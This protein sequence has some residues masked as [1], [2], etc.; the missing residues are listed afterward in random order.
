VSSQAYTPGLKRKELTIV[1]KTRI[2]PIKGEVLVKEGDVVTPNTVIA[3]TVVPGEKH[4]FNVAEKLGVY[5]EKLRDCLLKKEGELFKTNEVIA[6]KTG[7]FGLSKREYKSPVTGTIE[8]ISDITGEVIISEPPVPVEIN[9]YIPGTIETILPKE[10]AIVK[11]TAT[12]LQGIF[13]I[14]GETSGELV[15]LAQHSEDVIDETY[16]KPECNGKIL[17]GGAF[18]TG[19]ALVKAK[20]LGARGIVVG[21]IMNEALHDMLGYEIGVAITGN[22]DIDLT[23][24]IMEGFGKMKMSEH[25][26]ELL[27]KA[28]GRLACINGATQIRAGVIRPEVI[29]PRL[30]QHSSS[31]ELYQEESTTS[32]GLKSGTTIRVIRDPYFGSFGQVVNLPKELQKI[33]TE[34]KVRVLTAKL[35][36]GRIVIVPRADV[37][38]I[39][40]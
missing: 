32:E 29:I 18:I 8:R 31:I 37:E 23:L 6:L 14:G 12:F 22:E 7:F 33:E 25:V 36:D 24:T 28:E 38:I 30:D 20:E 34:S 2:L 27:K 16:I 3:R 4:L 9:A 19:K 26:F 1:K 39:E 17:V 15:M 40:E 13:G 5:P 11:T 10:G 35:H 21:G